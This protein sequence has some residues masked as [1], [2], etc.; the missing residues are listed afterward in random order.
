M[1]T[2]AL[3]S[4]LKANLSLTDV[5]VERAPLDEGPCIVIDDNGD[6]RD[7]H[8]SGGATTTGIKDQEYEVTVWADLSEGGPRYADQVADEII[9]LL[10]NFSGPM[11]D[12]QSSPNVSHRI[13]H[14]EATKG[15]GDF[16]PAPERYGYSVF[17]TVMNA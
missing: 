5:F 13:A 8:W 7:R 12:T 1:I 2:G 3:I 4:Y 14:I 11:V 17:L 15:G 16:D 9:T 10:D 6:S